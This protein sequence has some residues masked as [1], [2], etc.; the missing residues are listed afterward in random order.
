MSQRDQGR[1]FHIRDLQF[2][3]LTHIQQTQMIA[4]LQTLRQFYRADIPTAAHRTF[5]MVMPRHTAESLIIDQLGDFRVWPAYLAF[6]VLFELDKLKRHIQRIVQQQPADHR[7]ADPQ[8]Q[9][10][11][12]GSLQRTNR[13]RQDAQHPALGAGRHQPRRRRFGEQAAVA[14]PMARIENADLS[15]EAE[16]RAVNIGLAGQYA[17]VVGQ[18]AGG[19]VI[20]TVDNQIV[21]GGDAHGIL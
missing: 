2:V 14:R 1:A 21:I 18:I 12:F 19:K 6:G 4:G 13:T 9:L 15:I 16:D 5:L 3:R 20:R 10:E 11:R 7:L 17:Q 8:D